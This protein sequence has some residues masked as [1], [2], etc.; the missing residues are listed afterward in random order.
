MVLNERKATYTGEAAKYNENMGVA[1]E[2]HHTALVIFADVRKC[3]AA[4]SSVSRGVSRVSLGCLAVSR[5]VSLLSLGCLSGV[6]RCL[7]VSRAHSR[8]SWQQ[9]SEI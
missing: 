2:R 1:A 9:N 6:S 8:H 5:G 3:L 4:V 7:A